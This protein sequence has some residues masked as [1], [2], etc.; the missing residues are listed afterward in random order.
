LAPKKVFLKY[1]NL[2]MTCLLHFNIYEIYTYVFN[3]KCLCLV[4]V[5]R[6][7]LAKF[8][9]TKMF[10]LNLLGPFQH[11][12]HTHI[13]ATNQFQGMLYNLPNYTNYQ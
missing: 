13:L 3:L 6:L 9:N 10:H 5:Y 4:K 11:I 1:L 8:T 7:C 12:S 2:N